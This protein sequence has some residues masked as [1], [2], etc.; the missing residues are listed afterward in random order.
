MIQWHH[1]HR[2]LHLHSHWDH[3]EGWRCRMGRTFSCRVNRKAKLQQRVCLVA[4]AVWNYIER[5]F[6]PISSSKHKN[7]CT[8]QM[9]QDRCCQ[10]TFEFYWYPCSWL[11]TLERVLYHNRLRRILDL[12]QLKNL[13]KG[14]VKCTDDRS[15]IIY[16]WVELL[17]GH[18]SGDLLVNE[19]A[20]VKVLLGTSASILLT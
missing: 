12:R 15:F 8:F 16:V 19:F 5:F 11:S 1:N 7:L 13:G 9:M 14:N 17:L 6:V 2:Q 3:I 10:L 18:L 20:H 4:S